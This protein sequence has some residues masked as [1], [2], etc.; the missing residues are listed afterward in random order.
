[1]KKII[2][3]VFI[4][5]FSAAVVLADEVEDTLAGVANEQVMTATRQMIQNGIEQDDAIRLTRMMVQNQFSQRQTLQAQQM[6]IQALQS[7]LPAR[8]IMNKALEGMIKRIESGYILRA[9]DAVRERYTF[10]YQKAGQLTDKPKEMGVLGNLMADALTAGFER[11]DMESIM[12]RLQEMARTM[13]RKGIDALATEVCTTLRDMARLGV[14]SDAIAGVVSEALSQDYTA[15]KMEALR[16]TFMNS[17]K[18][19]SPEKIANSYASQ[20][21]QGE[22]PESP[23]SPGAGGDGSSG[24]SGGVGSSGGSGSGSEGASGAGA[25]SGGSGQSRK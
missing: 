22:S 7:G 12:T 11:R 6:L 23:G 1:M 9:M 2:A 24:E 18:K 15:Q 21:R 25:G 14:S 13:E 8:P 4:L 3:I 17:A 20:M 19:G 5:L 10:A 16:E